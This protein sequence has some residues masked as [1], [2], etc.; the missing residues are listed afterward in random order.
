METT[1]NCRLWMA[2]ARLPN[3]LGSAKAALSRCESGLQYRFASRKPCLWSGGFLSS[4]G[5]WQMLC[6]CWVFRSC[7][8]R[9]PPAPTKPSR[10]IWYAVSEIVP[11]WLLLHLSP[12]LF[13][14]PISTRLESVGLGKLKV[15]VFAVTMI[16]GAGYILRSIKSDEGP[17][18]PQVGRVA[19]L[20]S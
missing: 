18:I 14:Y 10:P 4:Y 9:S 7:I 13:E 17:N 20:S 8:R 5:L 16:A 15:V 19:Q 3:S 1:S 6:W 11:L 2:V 12:L